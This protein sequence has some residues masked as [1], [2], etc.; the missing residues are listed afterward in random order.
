MVT[1]EKEVIWTSVQRVELIAL[2]KALQLEKEKK[3]KKNSHS[4]Y[5]FA[6]IHFN[7]SI[8]RETGLLT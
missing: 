4:W 6:K 1:T 7:G 2:I 8:C 5:E 3:K